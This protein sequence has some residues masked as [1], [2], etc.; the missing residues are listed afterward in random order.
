MPLLMLLL[1]AADPL[2]LIDTAR[3]LTAADHRC[4]ASADTTDVTVCGLRNADRFRVPFV[5]YEP[6]DPRAE[7]VPAERE[8]L[9]ARTNNCQE[10]RA[11]AAG[12]GFA[13]V[14]MTTSSRGTTIMGA[15][16]LAP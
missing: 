6:G 13:G 15:R 5:G 11:I 14:R 12:C 3:R 2:T 9:L 7:G 4:V 8:R 10:R 16:K 1:A